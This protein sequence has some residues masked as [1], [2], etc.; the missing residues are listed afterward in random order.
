[1]RKNDDFTYFNLLILC[2]WLQVIN[3]VKVTHQCEGHIKVKVKVSSSLP[4]ICKI[5]QGEGHIK[6]K[7][8][9]LHLFKFYVAHTLCKRVVCI[10]LKRY[11]CYIDVTY[12]LED[13]LLV[14]TSHGYCNMYNG[15]SGSMHP[16]FLLAYFTCDQLH[17]V[18]LTTSNLI[19]QNMLLISGTCCNGTF[20]TLISI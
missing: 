9:Y 20:K 16:S 11:L 10:R 5:H 1:M 18:P 15:R 8:K 7:V 13:P 19:R 2:V 14:S 17:R 4:T 3:K 12:S 6:V